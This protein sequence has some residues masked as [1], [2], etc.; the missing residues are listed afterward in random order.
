MA[1]ADPQSR[2]EGGPRRRLRNARRAAPQ[3]EA[4]RGA[5]PARRALHRAAHRT[6]RPY[7]QDEAGRPPRPEMAACDRG[8]SA[9]ASTKRAAHRAALFNRFGLRTA[10]DLALTRYSAAS[11][12]SGAAARTSASTWA[13][14]LAKFFWNMPTSA[15][16]VLSN[17]ALSFQVLTGSRISLGTP[18]SAVGTAKPKY[19]SVRNSTLRKR[20]VRAPRSAARASP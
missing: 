8:M 3:A 19:L 18:G 20:A 9:F 2:D 4:F 14:N 11:L 6:R 17:S 5:G 10:L 15:R 12:R 13:S 7:P 1:T 16:A